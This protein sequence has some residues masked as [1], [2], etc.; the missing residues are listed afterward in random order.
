[1]DSKNP[2]S[3]KLFS[4]GTEIKQDL[5]QEI[6]IWLKV[7]LEEKSYKDFHNGEF[8]YHQANSVRDCDVYII[9][10]P[11]FGDK[12]NLAYDIAECESFVYAI[13]QG[14]PN[15]ITV[16]IPCLPYSRQDR[17]SNF[18]EPVLVQ[19]L[20]AKLQMLGVDRIVTMRLHNASSYNAHPETISINNIKTDSLFVDFIKKRG[21]DLDKLVLVS[22]D[23]GAA[24]STRKIA[25]GLG[26]PDRLVIIDKVRDPKSSNQNEVM[27]VIGD[28][29]GFDCIIPDDMADTCGTALKS[30][31]ALREKGAKRIYFMAVHGILSGSAL[32]NLQNANFDGVWFGDTCNISLVKTLPNFEAISTSRLISRIVDNLHNGESIHDLYKNGN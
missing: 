25:E 27:N 1:M 31:R 2:Y 3:L 20:P 23:L 17:P 7:S 19:M 26:I 15:R 4:V 10:Q 14:E 32:Q 22:P 5:A 30:A 6:S 21:F 11:R 24:A 8:L 16:I 9:F 18:R 12:K 29:E 28:P 13:S